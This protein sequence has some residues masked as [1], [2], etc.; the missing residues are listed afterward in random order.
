MTD[1]Y[2]LAIVTHTAREE[3]F[4]ELC[5]QVK[6]DVT[7]IDDGYRGPGKNHLNAINQAYGHAVE[8]YRQWVVVLEDDAVPIPDFRAE[9]NRCLPHAPSP[10]VSLYLGTGYP[11][12]YQ[13][14]FQEAVQQDVPWIIHPHMRHAVGYCLNTQI[15][16]SAR[17]TVSPMV[18]KNWAPDDALSLY[19]KKAGILVSYTN[20]S[21][22]DHRDT[23]TVIKSGRTHMGMPV[24]GRKKPR[25]AHRF[26]KPTEWNDS[27]TA[28]EV[29]ARETG[30]Q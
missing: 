17:K 22:V 1:I 10:L 24:F 25:K 20:P 4:N 2:T 23:E 8:H 13:A 21:L 5:E 27:Y 11:A 30:Q 18:D 14:R 16:D 12:Q 15:V 26:G 19:S 7:S 9:L 28:V 3:M 29:K 6:P